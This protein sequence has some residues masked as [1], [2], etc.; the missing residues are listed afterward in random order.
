MLTIGRI[1]GVGMPFTNQMKDSG[2]DTIATTPL[3]YGYG[4]YQ[5]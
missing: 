4:Y 2:P 5:P 3:Q 1:V